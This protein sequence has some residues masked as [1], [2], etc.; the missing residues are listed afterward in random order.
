MNFVILCLVTHL[1]PPAVAE[2]KSP[3]RT[4]PTAS[5]PTSP[6]NPSLGTEPKV[7][8]KG[9][10]KSS[11]KVSSNSSAN[12]LSKT[13]SPKPSSNPKAPFTPPNE[14]RLDKAIAEA[15]KKLREGKM[16][17]YAS[18][19][20]SKTQTSVDTQIEVRQNKGGDLIQA[21]NTALEKAATP[22][23]QTH[24]QF[25]E[26][27]H[28]G[29]VRDALAV[30]YHECGFYPDAL[31]KLMQ[32]TEQQPSCLHGTKQAPLA[33]TPQ[34]RDTIEKL[35]YLPY[36]YDDFEISLRLYWTRD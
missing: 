18:T 21:T 6:N 32:P 24:S 10:S 3:M 29:L 28:A 30:F 36:G 17:K 20:V 19:S 11:L 26:Q 34:N 14:E 4:L 9:F 22:T 23:V 1:L 35:T 15:E 33:N 12:T 25:V 5:A 7:P 8:A 2:I 16:N 13:S 27:A 31:D